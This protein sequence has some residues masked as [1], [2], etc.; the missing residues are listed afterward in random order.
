MKFREFLF[1]LSLFL[2]SNVSLA[3]SVEISASDVDDRIDIYVNGAHQD[4]CEWNSNPGCFA[5]IRGELSGS[6]DIRFKLTNYVYRG[7]CLAG[8]CG[9]YAADLEIRMNGSLLWSK[10][11]YRRDNSEGVKYDATIRCNFSAGVCREL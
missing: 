2:F 11:I 8:G 1:L 10:S 6:N 3:A 9:K 5:G 4:S 7:F